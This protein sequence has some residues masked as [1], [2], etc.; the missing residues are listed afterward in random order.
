M[1]L[2]EQ[3]PMRLQDRERVSR[4]CWEIRFLLLL[5]LLQLLQLQLSV[6]GSMPL[7]PAS[8]LQPGQPSGSCLTAIC[9]HGGSCSF[10]L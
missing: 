1:R 4:S 10:N 2:R 7:S 5:L 8:T 6:S 3:A 9:R